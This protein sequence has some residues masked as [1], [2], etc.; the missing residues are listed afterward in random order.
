MAFSPEG[1][2]VKQSRSSEKEPELLLPGKLIRIDKKHLDGKSET[3]SSQCNNQ[4]RAQ[5]WAKPN[6]LVTNHF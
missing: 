3:P 5:P 6:S 2:E 1:V 4:L